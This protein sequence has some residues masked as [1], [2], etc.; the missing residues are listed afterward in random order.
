[1]PVNT[2]VSWS[3]PPSEPCHIIWA[4]CLTQI[5]SP[6]DCPY[7]WCYS[8]TIDSSTSSRG[9]GGANTS[10]GVSKQAKNKP[11]S[12]LSL[13]G[14]ILVALLSTSALMP[15][16]ML[17]EYLVLKCS[18]IHHFVFQLC[19]C[20]TSADMLR[21]SPAFSLSRRLHPLSRVVFSPLYWTMASGW[22]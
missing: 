1:M 10:L 11:G 2:T 4:S 9:N 8:R 12:I 3:A 6:Q 13:S 15:S 20:D 7:T 5:D 18:S 22:E 19:S 14:S 17:Q 16:H 21:C